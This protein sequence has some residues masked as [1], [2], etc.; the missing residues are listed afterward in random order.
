MTCIDASVVACQLR[1]AHQRD[2]RPSLMRQVHAQVGLVHRR[3]RM[4]RHGRVAV[5]AED[6]VSCCGEVVAEYGITAQR[7]GSSQHGDGL[8]GG[9]RPA[10]HVGHMADA[11]HFRSRVERRAHLVVGERGAQRPQLSQHRLELR[12]H[13]CR[14]HRAA[15]AGY[16]H[17]AQIRKLLLEEVRFRR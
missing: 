17:A 15:G 1:Q 12:I 3:H 13:L 7:R 4:A 2:T 9:E 11:A 14:R 8:A 10:R 16:T 6:L 5:E